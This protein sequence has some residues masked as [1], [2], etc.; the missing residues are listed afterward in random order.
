MYHKQFCLCIG[1][2]KIVCYTLD[3]TLALFSIKQ[4]RKFYE[5]NAR[6]F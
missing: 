6:R 1:T 4:E 3:L 5:G 2:N